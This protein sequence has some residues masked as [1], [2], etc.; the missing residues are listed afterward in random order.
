MW[1]QSVLV[2]DQYTQNISFWCL[3]NISRLTGPK[4]NSWFLM[5]QTCLSS[6]CP[7]T[8]NDNTIDSTT[9]FWNLQMLFSFALFFF[10]LINHY[11]LLVLISKSSASISNTIISVQS[12]NILCLDKCYI[13]LNDLPTFSLSISKLFIYFYKSILFLIY[14]LD[15]ICHSPA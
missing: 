10:F 1:C 9:Q 6:I 2:L 3:I 11:V 14:Q 12:S 4:R 5:P 8:V 7:I 13:L 15:Q